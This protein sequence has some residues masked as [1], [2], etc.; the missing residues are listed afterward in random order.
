M[1]LSFQ[2]AD[3]C[4]AIWLDYVHPFAGEMKPLTY[5]ASRKFVNTVQQHLVATSGP[6]LQMILFRSAFTDTLY[7]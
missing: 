6:G 2:E 4:A 3:G 5:I 7:R 1:A